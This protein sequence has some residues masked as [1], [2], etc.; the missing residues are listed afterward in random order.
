MAEGESACGSHV[1]VQIWPSWPSR[2]AGASPRQC[3]Q[4]FWEVRLGRRK[5]CAPSE[6][7]IGSWVAA[8]SGLFDFEA[9]KRGF[10]TGWYGQTG[11]K[12]RGS[13]AAYVSDEGARWM[14]QHG[15]RAWSDATRQP[16]LTCGASARGAVEGSFIDCSHA[17]FNGSQ[18]PRHRTATQ[19]NHDAKPGNVGPT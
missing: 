13:R 16:S 19:S 6:P 18:R 14:L 8:C 7:P 2:R 15:R 10:A 3:G 1:A 17:A 9:V 5:Q 12:L 4:P 11:S